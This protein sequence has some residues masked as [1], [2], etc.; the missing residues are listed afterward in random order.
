MRKLISI[1]VISAF[2]A[3][4]YAVPPAAEPAKAENQMTP[5][6]NRMK[7]CNAEAKEKGLK[8]Q[9]RKDFMKSCLSGDKK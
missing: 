6:Q 2:A 1:A 4:A 8:K 3:S 5:Q 9:G 7:M